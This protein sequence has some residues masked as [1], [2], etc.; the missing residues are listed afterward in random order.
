ME[1]KNRREKLTITEQEVK[2]AISKLKKKKTGEDGIRNEA[3]LNA[4]E[5]TI[6]KIRDIMQRI[7]NGKEASEGWKEE[8]IYPI[9]KKGDRQKAENYRGITLMD[10]I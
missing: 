9:Y 1:G 5:K 7:G 6:E 4:D 2:K 8:W 3:W 10:R